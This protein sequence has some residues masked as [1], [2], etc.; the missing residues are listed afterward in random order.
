MGNLG[1]RATVTI[2]FEIHERRRSG[3]G[4]PRHD[5]LDRKANRSRGEDAV[6]PHDLGS[7]AS[8]P[9]AL[10]LF[11]APLIF[12]DFECFSPDQNPD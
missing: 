10:V 4:E 3:A 2:V 1:E 6:R 8:G 7:S 11:C 12:L 9:V 5:D